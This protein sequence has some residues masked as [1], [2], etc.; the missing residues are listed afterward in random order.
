MQI[1]VS[2]KLHF[3]LSEESV[4]RCVIY[5]LGFIIDYKANNG[6]EARQ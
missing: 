1:H 2:G 4:R 5:L 6:L 3:L